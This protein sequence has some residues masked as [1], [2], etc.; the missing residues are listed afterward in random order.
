MGTRRFEFDGEDYVVVAV[1]L[2]VQGQSELPGGA[3]TPAERAVAALVMG[4]RT[5]AEIAAMRN[6]SRYTIA[7]QIRALFAKLGVRSRRELAQFLR[8]PQ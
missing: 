3:L 5:N 1:S 8:D 6:V 4:G 2:E 7:A